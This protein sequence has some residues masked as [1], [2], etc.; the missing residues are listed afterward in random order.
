MLINMSNL[1]TFRFQENSTHRIINGVECKWCPDCPGGQNWHP[2]IPA[3]V[4]GKVKDGFYADANR[5]DGRAGICISCTNNRQ[6]GLTK[7]KRPWVKVDKSLKARAGG[8]EYLPVNKSVLRKI[9]NRRPSAGP[10]KPP[11]YSA[12]QCPLCLKDGKQDDEVKDVRYCVGCRQ[13]WSYSEDSAVIE[14]KAYRRKHGG[15]K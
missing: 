10:R 8:G 12:A 4:A 5:K 15:K 14:K 3:E 9:T 7:K 11:R 1:T 6:A 2:M 13:A